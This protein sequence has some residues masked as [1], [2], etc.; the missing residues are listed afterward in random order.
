M[1][2]C[3]SLRSS[4]YAVCAVAGMVL[5]TQVGGCAAVERDEAESTEQ[6]L[7]AGGFN[8]KAADT[9]DKLGKLQAM[10]QRRILQRQGPDGQPQFVFADATY[11][12][13]LFVGDE[14]AYQ[15]Y[16][17]LSVEQQIAEERQQAEMDASMNAPWP[18]DWWSAPY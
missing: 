9:P 17:R 3:S 4:M 11:C 18:Y 5:M 16:Q 10:K 12:R 15:S 2:P 14:A 1:T 8:I 6:L 7:S 13:C